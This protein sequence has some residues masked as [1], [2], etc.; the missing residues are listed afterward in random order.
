MIIK[1]TKTIRLSNDRKIQKSEVGVF[2]YNKLYSYEDVVW[3]SY[4][5]CF[6]VPP[7]WCVLFSNL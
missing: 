2:G 7:T 3:K 4:G 1:V 5:A 6:I